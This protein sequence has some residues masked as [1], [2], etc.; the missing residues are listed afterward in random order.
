NDIFIAIRGTNRDGHN[1]IDQA[2]ENGASVIICEQIPDET[3][4][5]F[6]IQVENSRVLTGPLAQFL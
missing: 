1:F 2:V 4:G 3:G 6:F 5:S